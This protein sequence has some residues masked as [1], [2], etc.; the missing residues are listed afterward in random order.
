MSLCTAPAPLVNPYPLSK[1]V[2]GEFGDSTAL[3]EIMLN[4]VTKGTI[5]STLAPSIG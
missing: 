3:T 2:F 5:G 1:L 4:T